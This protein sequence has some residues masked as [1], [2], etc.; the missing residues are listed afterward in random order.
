M[1]KNL[2]TGGAGFIG[3]HIVDALLTRGDQVVIYDNLST[4]RQENIAQHENATFVEGCI[5]DA[6]QLSSALSGVE[7]VFHQ[8]ALASVPLSVERPLDTN[9]H[10]VTGTLNV[11]NEARKANVKRVVYAASSSAYGDQ[12]F[13]AKRETDLPAP[14]SPYAV[15]KLAGE[16]YC[17]AFYHTYGLETVGLRYFNVFGPRQDPDSPYSA[18]IPIFLT[19][20]L[21]G[22]Q[23]VVY[24]DG[25]QSRDFTYVKNIVNANLAA[26]TAE[27]VAGRIINVA[28]GKSTSLL[29]LLKL[30]N[31]QLGTDIQP[32]HDPPR[33]GDVRDSMADNTLATQLLQYEIEVDFEE[34]LKQSVEYYRQLALQRS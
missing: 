18:V 34:G 30:L 17:Q 3:S 10:C 20:L 12:P 22:K 26:A 31:E 24:G 6:Q 28:N 4:G 11:L 33:A 29:T 23:P 13:L 7:Y 9:L 1:A 21:Q 27:D 2:V 16:Y 32:K 8:A 14:L 5:T 15:A 25:N 19:L